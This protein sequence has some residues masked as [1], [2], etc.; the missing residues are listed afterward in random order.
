MSTKATL[1]TVVPTGLRQRKKVDLRNRLLFSA[2]EL[3]SKQGLEQST[4]DD[5]CAACDVSRRTFYNYFAS[6]QE[7]VAELSDRFL[8]QESEKVINNALDEP[9]S[10]AERLTQYFIY[11]AGKANYYKDV[12]RELI[13]VLLANHP[14]GQEPEKNLLISMQTLFQKLFDAGFEAGDIETDYS[15][16]FL[17][18]MTVGALNNTMCNWA[19]DAD[20]PVAERLMEIP[21]FILGAARP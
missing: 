6:K 17:A 8:V 18:E 12:E 21:R 2:L 19:H 3:F 9:I 20:Y 5:I 10:T 7:L 4:L 15:S 13:L 14:T 16:E 11:I 1:Q